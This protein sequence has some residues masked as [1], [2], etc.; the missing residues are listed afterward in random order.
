MI[1]GHQW[2]SKIANGDLRS[3][4]NDNHQWSKINSDDEWSPEM[5]ND[6]N[7]AKLQWVM[8][9]S[10]PQDRIAKSQGTAGTLLPPN[11]PHLSRATLPGQKSR[12]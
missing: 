4:I 8:G 9:S 11:I 1:E 12:N 6:H 3:M 7:G 10:R 5:I 2:W